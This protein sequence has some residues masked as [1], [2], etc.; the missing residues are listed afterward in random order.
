MG[1]LY[2]GNNLDILLRHLK[3]ETVDLADPYTEA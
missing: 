3:D 2:C 1:M